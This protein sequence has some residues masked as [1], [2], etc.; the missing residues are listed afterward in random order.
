MRGLGRS[1]CAG[2]ELVGVVVHCVARS[3]I[4]AGE[5][6]LYSVGGHCTARRR[7]RMTD[8]LY[9]QRS[10]PPGRLKLILQALH[11]GCPPSIDEFHGSW[12]SL[13]VS[14]STYPGFQVLEMPDSITAVAGGP[15]VSGK[16]S[17]VAGSENTRRV[18]ESWRADAAAAVL[19]LSGPFA[20]LRIELET[21]EVSIATDLMGL[22][23]V[24]VGQMDE[25]PVLGTHVDAV[26]QAMGATEIDHISAM[27]FVVHGT[28]TYPYTC[29]KAVRQLPPATVSTWNWANPAGPHID[30]YWEPREQPDFQLTLSEAGEELRNGLTEFVSGVCAGC[31]EIGM[32]LSGGEDSRLV[33]SLIPPGPKKRGFVF[34]D[35]RNREGTVAQKVADR[36]GVD[37]A[38]GLRR[39]THYL[40]S[41]GPVSRLIGLGA[42][43]A[44]AHSFGFHRDY[45]LGALPAVLGGYFSDVLIKGCD[46]RKFPPTGRLPIFPEIRIPGRRQ[47]PILAKA[48]LP[49][50]LIREVMVRREAHYQRLLKLR[51]NTADEWSTFWPASMDMGNPNIA[52]NRRLFASFEPFTASRVIHLAAAVPQHWKLNR[53]LIWAAAHPLLEKT[54]DVP[55]A[56]GSYPHLPWHLNLLR[57]GP[58]WLGRTAWRKL[59][60]SAL[61]EGPW[62]QWD[63]DFATT[64]WRDS[65]SRV[66]KVGLRIASD[67]TPGR[68]NRLLHGADL[69]E[70]QRVN[71]LQL[72]Q[73]LRRQDGV[74]AH[75]IEAQDL[76]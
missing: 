31:N 18:N 3:G 17:T 27:D 23:P 25:G 36:L 8:F 49:T 5:D 50:D 62:N 24:F 65:T 15:L 64:E 38:L 37:L 1:Q 11:E 61:N 13:A 73:H 14:N 20:I 21:R 30:T 63:R 71:L 68:I 19:Q 4:G 76:A 34:L 60:R 7:L 6:R 57:R 28:V 35:S 22:I 48:I 2:F 41:L 69:T 10:Q 39:T 75:S 54:K 33:A 51:P 59:S 44:H 42:E 55:H 53:R 26:A 9:S 46:I 12:G 67:L 29:Y 16:R 70:I 32:F 47:N 45:D 58:T 72:L 52:I 66:G 43:A 56:D 74:P 40:E